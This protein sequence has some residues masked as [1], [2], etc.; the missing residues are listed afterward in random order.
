MVRELGVI[1]DGPPVPMPLRRATGNVN[2]RG[3]SLVRSHL[4]WGR[5][6]SDR[7]FHLKLDQALELDAVFHREVADEIVH[8]PVDAQAHGLRFAYA[9]L[10]HV[11]NLLGAHLADTCFVLHG[12]AGAA[13]GDSR[14]SI[15]AAGRVDKKRVALGVVLA[16]LEMLRPVNQTA[17]S[18][19]AFADGD[20]FGNNVAGRF[21]GSMNH[22]RSGVLMLAVVGERYGKNFATRLATF[23]DH[24]GIFHGETGAD[25]AIDPFYLGV[26]LRETA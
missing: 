18:G 22:L 17:V 24:A 4:V 21:I 9:P 2:F 19:S 26:L 10:L 8:E 5:N 16:I 3:R 6:L 15:R 12:I 20:R 13:H 25:V 7:T 11:E 1:P 23:H 14:V